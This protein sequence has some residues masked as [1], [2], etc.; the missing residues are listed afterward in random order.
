MRLKRFAV[1]FTAAASALLAGPAP[2]YAQTSANVAVVINDKSPA[3]VQ[4]GEHY[5]RQ[6]GIPAENV[7]RVS[8]EPGD[9]IS[10]QRYA[11]DLEAPIARALTRGRLQDRVLYIVLTKGIPLRITGTTGL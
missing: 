2:G 10:R 4:I 5:V 1:A 7:V 3:S 9:T 6:R 8:I 11:L